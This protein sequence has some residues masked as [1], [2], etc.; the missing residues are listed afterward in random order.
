MDKIKKSFFKLG[1]VIFSFLLIACASEKEQNANES[2]TSEVVS[3]EQQT[4]VE[5]KTEAKQEV[6]KTQADD[7]VSSI[8]KAA[9][10]GDARAQYDLG[11]IYS[12]G[13]GVP[14]DSEQALYWTEKAAE[15]GYVYAQ[16]RLGSWYYRGKNTPKNTEKGIYWWKKA[17]ENGNNNA[18]RQ[19]KVIAQK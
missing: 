10:N 1:I 14:E 16:D 4:N 15:N 8:I 5:Q 19:L 13:G 3:S 2:Q 7:S 9:E 17:A 12:W 6:V 11:Y 18:A